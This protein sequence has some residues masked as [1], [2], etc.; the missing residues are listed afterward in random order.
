LRLLAFK[1]TIGPDRRAV[2]SDNQSNRKPEKK[3]LSG[4]GRALPNDIGLTANNVMSA[5]PMYYR[6]ARVRVLL[7]RANDLGFDAGIN[8][9]AVL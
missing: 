9:N 6:N 8:R 2:E 1:A 7:L 5:A 3:V 4:H